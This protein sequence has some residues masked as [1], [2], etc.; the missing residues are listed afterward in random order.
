MKPIFIY[1]LPLLIND[2]STP[3]PSTWWVLTGCSVPIKRKLYNDLKEECRIHIRAKQLEY[4][5]RFGRKQCEVEN[6]SK[7]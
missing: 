1:P 5:S 6:K 2:C 4:N 7:L 3:N